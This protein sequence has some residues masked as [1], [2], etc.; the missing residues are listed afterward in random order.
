MPAPNGA[1][2]I[3][4]AFDLN[5]KASNA[6]TRDAKALSFLPGIGN[7]KLHSMG[8]VGEAMKMGSFNDNQ[9]YLIRGGPCGATWLMRVYKENA[10]A[11]STISSLHSLSVGE[12]LMLYTGYCINTG[13]GDGGGSGGVY[14]LCYG[15]ASMKG[16]KAWV[17]GGTM[18]GLRDSAANGASLAT[19]LRHDDWDIAPVANPGAP[20]APPAGTP[21]E[22]AAGANAVAGTNAS[23]SGAPGGGA[24]SSAMGSS[25]GA[26]IL[27]IPPL[28]KCGKFG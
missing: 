15:V 6:V 1:Q 13:D 8:E 4:T 12:E 16:A 7:R 2:G 27:K 26:P 24:Q 20:P 25:G 10:G 9:K 11:S 21:Q 5:V 19:L 3:F 23:S 17:R 28:F 22:D 18:Q 14:H